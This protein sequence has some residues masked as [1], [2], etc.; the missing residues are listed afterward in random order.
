MEPEERLHCTPRRPVRVKRVD[1]V[2]S[3]HEMFMHCLPAFGGA[4]LRRIYTILDE[5]IGRG[6]PLTVSIAGLAG[7][8]FFPD[9]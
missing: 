2:S 1:E 6:C 9:C 4:Y 5:A 8:F 3:M 7:G